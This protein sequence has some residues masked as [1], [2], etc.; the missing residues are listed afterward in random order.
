VVALGHERCLVRATGRVVEVKW[1]Q[2]F[3][4]RNGLVCRHREYTDTAAWDAGFVRRDYIAT[5]RGSAMPT[6]ISVKQ[7]TG[8]IGAEIKGVDLKHPLD[9]TSFSIIHQ[10]FLDHCVLVFRGQSLDPPAQ[11]TFARRWG[12]VLDAPYLKPIEMPGQ[13]G[14][15]VVP[16]LGKERSYTTEVWHTDLSFM[17]TPP[18]LTMLAA[19]VVPEAGGDTMFAS[20]YRA[21]D[22]LSDGMKGILQGL[23]GVHGG[24]R[25][26][27]LFGIEDSALPQSHPIVRIHPETGRKALYV[28][29]LYTY[30]IEGLTQAESRGL[31]DFLF[32]QACRPDFTYRHQWAP[33]DVV[34][35]DNR[36]ALHYAVHDHGD[37][38]RV[39]NRTVI[40]GDLPR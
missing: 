11:M 27:G 35:W 24:G 30:S 12:E 25:L 9:D 1:V 21:Y 17:P 39:M 19:Q 33:G 23:R 14:M 7:L 2:I 40:A 38:P 10:A 16:N 18:A 31:L 37:A 22:T 8:S 28:N 15:L 32:Q 26:A 29:P 4:F 5:S 6:P 3:D 13:P 34:M 36:C 20:Q